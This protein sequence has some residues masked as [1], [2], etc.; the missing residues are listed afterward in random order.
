VYCVTVED[1]PA[2]SNVAVT[3]AVHHAGKVVSYVFV[4]HYSLRQVLVALLVTLCL[5][6]NESSGHLLDAFDVQDVVEGGLCAFVGLPPLGQVYDVPQ[7][8]GDDPR[9]VKMFVHHLAHGTFGAIEYVW[10]EEQQNEQ[11]RSLVGQR[12]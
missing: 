3:D 11:H 12:E 7:V 1:K 10:H 9:V 2:E 4:C 6:G 5:F 8:E